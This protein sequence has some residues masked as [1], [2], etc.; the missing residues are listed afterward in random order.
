[1]ELK[2]QQFM[3]KMKDRNIDPRTLKDRAKPLTDLIG[4]LDGKFITDIQKGNRYHAEYGIGSALVEVEVSG[5]AP[6]RV[7]ATVTSLQEDPNVANFDY[8]R[9]LQAL[10]KYE[11][12][13]KPGSVKQDNLS[14]AAQNY[15][16]QIA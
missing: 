3:V 13:E 15:K 5:V 9:V 10:R 12:E 8:Q 11:F 14:N 2:Q 16:I 6:A 1:M 7:Y 4:D